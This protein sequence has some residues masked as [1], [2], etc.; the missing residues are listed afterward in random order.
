MNFKESGNHKFKGEKI[1]HA[2]DLTKDGNVLDMWNKFKQKSA[3]K[4]RVE[5]S[6]S[7]V[8]YSLGDYLR[9]G[10]NFS[11]VA[12][13][14]FTASNG[15]PKSPSSLHYMSPASMNQYQRAISSVCSILMNYDYD[16]QIQ[17]FGFGAIPKF[18]GMPHQTSHFF[19]CSGNMNNTSGLGVEGVFQLYNN[20]LANVSLSGPTYFAPLL[21]Q[22]TNMTKIVAN[23]N[24]DNYTILLI[25]TDGVI[26]DMNETVEWIV[27]ASNLPMSII[28]IGVGNE[29]FSQMETLD[30][31][32]KKLKAQSG[33]TA[34]RDIVQFVPFA[35]CAGDEGLLANRVLK[36]LPDQVCNYFKMVQKKPNQAVKASLS[37]IEF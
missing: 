35:K 15:E 26:H 23:Q 12:C 34:K 20:V 4:I 25:L 19:P 11:V 27:E 22:V 13:I 24:P 5:S 9:G 16:K 17:T 10:L 32:S 30:G 6:R 31:D 1:I 21:E 33:A 8:V 7:E 37:K 36:E 3:G 18:Q 29:D 28:I 2:G 14:D